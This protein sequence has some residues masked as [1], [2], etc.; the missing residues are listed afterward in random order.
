MSHEKRGNSDEWYTPKWVFDAMELKFQMDVASPEDD[1]QCCVPAMERITKTKVIVKLPDDDEE[2]FYDSPGG[3][4]AMWRGLVW[5]NPPYGN[6]ADKME[7][8]MRF[9]QHDNIVALMPD[10]TSSSWWQSIANASHSIVIPKS[11]IKFTDPEGKTA[12]HPPTG[13]T[14]F[15]KGEE[16]VKGLENIARKGLGTHWKRL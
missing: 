13:S 12:G 2:T 10:R 8:I 9:A 4:V 5:M 3:L 6:Q 11:K 16:A 7:W 15:A 14:F 1:S